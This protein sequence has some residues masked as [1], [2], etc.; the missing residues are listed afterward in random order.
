VEFADSDCANMPLGVSQ[1]LSRSQ[2]CSI[3][4][5]IIGNIA[6]SQDMNILIYADDSHYY[7]GYDKC[8]PNESVHSKSVS[9]KPS[10]RQLA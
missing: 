4:K 10:S 9:C 5:Q 1:V 6:K 7:L 8:L 2:Y 3:Y